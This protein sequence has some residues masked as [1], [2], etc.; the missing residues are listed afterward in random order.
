MGAVRGAEGII[1]VEIGQAGKLLGKLLVVG[2]FFGMKAEILQQQGLALFQLSRHLLGFR[3][4]AFGAEA[5]VF[6]GGQ[7]LVE[8]HAQAFRDR[9]EAHFRVWFPL[10]PAEMRNQN[11]AGAAT[12]G[13]L[14][15]G[16]SLADAGVVDNAAVFQRDV[17]VHPHEDAVIGKS[18]IANGKFCHDGNPLA[19]PESIGGCGSGV[20]A[21]PS[22]A[23]APATTQPHILQALASQIVDQVADA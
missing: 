11:H 8:Q 14:D 21:A 6:V 20:C 1:H 9:F 5:D 7:F 2:F 23:R 12:Q 16:Q 22:R 13:V 3:T 4:D 17:E 10:G 19:Q 18:K 15:G